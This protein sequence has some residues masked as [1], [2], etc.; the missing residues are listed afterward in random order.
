MKAKR[1]LEIA[2]EVSFLLHKPNA[3]GMLWRK[4]RQ[5]GERYAG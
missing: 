2:P 1:L 5:T 3:T 4:M